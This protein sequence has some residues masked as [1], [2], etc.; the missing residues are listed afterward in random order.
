MCRA[1]RH[2]K[3]QQTKQNTSWLLTYL[4]VWVLII[5][6]NF[7]SVQND[8]MQKLLRNL[9]AASGRN[10]VTQL[11]Q[12]LFPLP[13]PGKNPEVEPRTRLDLAKAVQECPPMAQLS[14]G[15]RGY[16]SIVRREG[17]WKEETKILMFGQT[18]RKIQSV[19]MRWV[20]WSF[21]THVWQSMWKS[22]S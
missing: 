11:F 16:S 7:W 20:S 3:L 18:L 15:T 2:T 8:K 17:G 22:N 10:S 4:H 9:A 14:Q 12:A 19:W 6:G 5:K 21:A 1:I 13:P